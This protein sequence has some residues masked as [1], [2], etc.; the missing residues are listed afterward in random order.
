MTRTPSEGAYYTQ[1]AS[2]RG[3][4]I[5]AAD[6]VEPSALQE[7]ARIIAV[8]LD[9]RRDIADCIEEDW[10]SAFA[11]FPKGHP[12]TDLPEFSYLEGKKDMWGQS[13]DNPLEIDGLGPTTLNPVTAASEW[14]LTA[15]LSY[16]RQRYKVAV[17]EFAHHL[18]NLCFTPGDHRTLEE[19]RQSSLG[20]GYGTGL[21]VNADEFFAGLSEVY[22]SIDTTI[23]R[24][25][26]ELFPAEVMG[27]LEE[28]Y[29]ILTPMGTGD[30]SHVQHVT[31]SGIPLP[32]VTVAPR[33]FEHDTLGYRIELLPGWKVRQES[34]YETLLVGNSSEI[35][36]TYTDLPSDADIGREL[37][38]LAETQ[39]HEWEQWT[40]G[41]DVAEVKSYERESLD[42]QHSYWIRYYGHES[43][44]YCDIDIIERVAITSH[45]GKEYGV[46]LQG[47]ICGAGIHARILDLDSIMRSF[48]P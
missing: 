22:F 39:R 5:K 44:N 27:F 37:V 17:H 38:H 2:I 46:V 36:I 11:I 41:W 21:T 1:Y 23:P 6:I 7:A 26:L 43:P 3:V 29:G 48:S 47:H 31:S 13:Y 40:Q 30:P 25:H 10:D 20:L 14:G 15:D 24:R 35:S 28:F 9:G 19:L 8:M 16:P 42:G 32:W 4:T 18:M 34:A 33:T 45:K 12:V